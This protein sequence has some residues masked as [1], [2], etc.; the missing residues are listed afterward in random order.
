MSRGAVSGVSDVGN[1]RSEAVAQ[2]IGDLVELRA[3]VRHTD[4]VSSG[5]SECA[6]M[7]R[8]N[9]RP[10]PV[11]IVVAPNRPSVWACGDWS[12]VVLTFR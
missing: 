12:M 7:A 8:P 2:L 11:T 6:A 5:G 3:G 1:H 9:P 4:D 10:A